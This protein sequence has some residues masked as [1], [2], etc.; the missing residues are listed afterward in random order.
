MILKL[1][2]L[3]F[4]WGGRLLGSSWASEG[5]DKFFVFLITFA[6][7]VLVFHSEK[8]GDAN[9]RRV[10]DIFLQNVCHSHAKSKHALFAGS[11]S[12][13]GS[14]FRILFYHH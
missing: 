4:F 11:V 3:F 10:S 1:S 5:S 2:A 6:F 12:R 8:K 14:G 9:G 13:T 7:K